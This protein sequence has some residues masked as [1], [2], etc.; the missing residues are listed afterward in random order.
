MTGRLRVL[1]ADDEL[2]ARKRLVRLLGELPDVEVAG[3]CADGKGVLEEVA[4]GGVDVVLLDIHMPGLSGLEALRLLPAD[5]PLVVFC[6][7][8]AE[9]AL[10]AFDAGALDYVLKPIEGARLAKALARARSRV[11]RRRFRAEADRQRAGALDR[12]AVATR[13]GIVLLDPRRIGHAVLDGELVTIA[14]LDGDYL[15]DASL[16]DLEARLPRSFLR[17]HRRALLNLEQVVRL[18]P[19]ASGGFLARTARGD[20]VQVSRQAARELRR[21]LGL[22]RAGGEGDGEGER[23]KRG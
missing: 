15:T 23:G 22:R 21:A 17:V 5:G 9:H 1:V 3:V 10:D 7:A 19:T 4:R 12:I 16:S 13:G 18:E 20:G 6:T 11:A 2:M 14:T 8:H